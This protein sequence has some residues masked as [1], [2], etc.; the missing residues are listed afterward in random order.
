MMI[1]GHN[2]RLCCRSWRL[3]SGAGVFVAI[4][5]EGKVTLGGPAA[6][7]PVGHS[8]RLSLLRPLFDFL[9]FPLSIF[10]I[11]F[12]KLSTPFFIFVLPLSLS[13]PRPSS[14]LH[15][16]YFSSLLSSQ[17]HSF[18]AASSLSHPLS[19]SFI[20]QTLSGPR[21]AFKCSSRRQ[22]SHSIR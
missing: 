16:S 14:S 5:C 8:L 2:G 20:L 21:R 15:L 6:L 4:P 7:D 3:R 22:P 12:I 9:L 13:F 19:P 18:L 11:T 10:F 17:P 1:D